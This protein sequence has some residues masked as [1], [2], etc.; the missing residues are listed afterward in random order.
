MIINMDKKAEIK[1]NL[2]GCKDVH[3][4]ATTSRPSKNVRQSHL[5]GFSINCELPTRVAY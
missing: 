2:V 3:I 1:A 4:P 5:K